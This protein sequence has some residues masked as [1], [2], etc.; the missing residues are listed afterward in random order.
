MKTYNVCTYQKYYS[1]AQ[2][3]LLNGEAETIIPDL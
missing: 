1:E 2:D 3:M